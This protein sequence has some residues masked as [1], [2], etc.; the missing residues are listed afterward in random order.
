MGHPVVTRWRLQCPTTARRRGAQQGITRSGAVW[1][2][3]AGWGRLKSQEVPG[4]PGTAGPE[5]LGETFRVLRPQHGLPYL[6]LH[7]KR[8]VSTEGWFRFCAIIDGTA[9]V[10]TTIVCLLKYPLYV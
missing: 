2:G 1:T 5:E 9:V 6:L 3:C 7:P 8:V 4:G 10:G